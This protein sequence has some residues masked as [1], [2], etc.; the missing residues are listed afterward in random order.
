MN[1]HTEEKPVILPTEEQIEETIS[2]IYDR[3]ENPAVNKALNAAVKE[4][5]EEAIDILVD[6]KRTYFQINSGMKTQQGRAIAVLAV[7]YL[8]GECSQEVLLGVPIKEKAEW[9]PK[10]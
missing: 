4:G 1:I 7:D 6:D 5:Y 8:N 10:K 2:K 9:K 3:L